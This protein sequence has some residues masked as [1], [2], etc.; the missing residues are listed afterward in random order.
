MTA[1]NLGNLTLHAYA[2]VSAATP[3]VV[4]D[5]VNVTGATR[6]G[7]GIT[8]VTLG[9]EIDDTQRM[10]IVTSTLATQGSVQKDPGVQTDST[11]GVLGFVAAVASDVSY[12]IAVYRT[13]KPS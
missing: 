3:P 13:S 6:T 1:P 5:A 4:T 10:V 12:E 2:K 8:V 7:A 11:V 9:S